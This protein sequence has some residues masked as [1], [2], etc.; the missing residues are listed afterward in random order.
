MSPVLLGQKRRKALILGSFKISTCFEI[1]G[2]HFL[3]P[4][5]VLAVNEAER[6]AYEEHLNFRLPLVMCMAHL[7]GTAHVYE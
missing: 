7:L 1:P 3:L 4:L 2:L 6:Y 5:K